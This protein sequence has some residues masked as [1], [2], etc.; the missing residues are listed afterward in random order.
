LSPRYLIPLAMFRKGG[1]SAS[2]EF[3]ASGGQRAQA[4]TA[5]PHAAIRPIS[6][7]R[8]GTLPADAAEGGIM[9]EADSIRIPL[10]G[11]D[12]EGQASAVGFAKSSRR[13]ENP[14]GPSG[15][16]CPR[17]GAFS[18]RPPDLPPHRK[19]GGRCSFPAHSEQTCRAAFAEAGLPH[20]ALVPGAGFEK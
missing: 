12:Q 1:T 16:N 10:Q 14:D 3:G 5:R 7:R 19:R 4:V 15:K 11:A 8:R 18:R 9:G 6:Q 20:P 2:E 13:A 17:P